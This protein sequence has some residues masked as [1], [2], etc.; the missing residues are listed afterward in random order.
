MGCDKKLHRMRQEGEQE[1]FEGIGQARSRKA[2][3]SQS[4]RNSS[5]AWPRVCMPP[6]L[7]QSTQLW[8]D[9]SPLTWGCAE[10]AFSSLHQ[11]QAN[12][13]Q[14]LYYRQRQA[15]NSLG[16]LCS[17]LTLPA[18]ETKRHLAY[19]WQPPPTLPFLSSSPSCVCECLLF[20]HTGLPAGDEYNLLFPLLT[21]AHVFDL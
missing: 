4:C 9:T 14:V 7:A 5:S 1:Y 12:L 20:L 6:G 11:A 17:L 21:S 10:V 19:A 16:L 13:M 18:R 3:Q 8:S 15:S 2:E